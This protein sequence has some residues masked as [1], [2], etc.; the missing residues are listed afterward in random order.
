MRSQRVGDV[1][2]ASAV[3]R[4][5]GQLG[6]SGVVALIAEVTGQQSNY[7]QLSGECQRATRC[8][9]DVHILQRAVQG[10]GN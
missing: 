6:V 4:L 2:A 10:L 1:D 7:F 3:S 9:R 5:I 8:M